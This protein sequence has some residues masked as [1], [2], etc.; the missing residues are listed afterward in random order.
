MHFEFGMRDER[1]P[2][3]RLERFRV[4]SDMFR[5]DRGD[6]NAGGGFLGGVASVAPH[7][8]ENTGA[9]ALGE[10]NG[11]DEVG[12]DVFLQVTAADRKNEQPV[13]GA[14][15]AAFEPLGQHR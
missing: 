15:A 1:V 12:A 7:N 5:V 3:H 9:D 2:A 13:L 10:L 4:W 14:E 11:G 8:A 6:E